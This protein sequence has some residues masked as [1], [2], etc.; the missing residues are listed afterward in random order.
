M[1]VNNA[2]IIL[3]GPLENQTLD[4]FHQAMN[5]NFFGALHTTLAVLPQMLARGNGA[6]V[7]HSDLSKCA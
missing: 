3:V 4:S 6:I 5:I 7:K 1:L 2:G